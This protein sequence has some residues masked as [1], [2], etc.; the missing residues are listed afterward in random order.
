MRWIFAACAALM[1]ACA[2]AAS[3]ADKPSDDS[4]AID[5]SVGRATRSL[6]FG[7]LDSQAEALLSSRARMPDGRWKLVFLLASFA[8]ASDVECRSD[9]A[10]RKLEEAAAAYARAHPKS[11]HAGLFQALVIEQVAW[12]ARGTGYADSVS[13]QGWELFRARMAEARRVLDS[14]RGAMASNPAWYENRIR[15]ARESGEPQPQSDALLERGI[16]VEPAY[17]QLYITAMYALMPQ[18]G[19]SEHAV[20][21]FIN[22]Y[23]RRP[24]VAEAEGLYARLIWNASCCTPGLEADPALDWEA[25][26]RGIDAVL[27]D[28][29][30]QRN[31]QRLFFM[32]CSHPDKAEAVKLLPLIEGPPIEQA[33]GK[34]NV[35]VYGMCLDWARGKVGSFVMREP[36]TG[37]TKLIH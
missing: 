6:D 13:P 22:D 21:R 24:P 14:G 30:A 26:R 16:A 17:V 2:G 33:L 31:V 23:G 20:L 35:P 4:A 18:W 29:P 19:G 36:Q 10:C 37:S 28:Y 15:V 34:G 11:R 32:A 12:K 5:A 7:A 25:A 1:L 3:A 8:D 27:R 9:A